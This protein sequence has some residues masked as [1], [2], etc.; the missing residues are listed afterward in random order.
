M[1]QRRPRRA[2]RWSPSRLTILLMV[3]AQVLVL[4][5][6]AVVGAGRYLAAPLDDDGLYA[7]L[8]MGSDQGPPRSGSALGGRMDAIQLVVVTA[9]RQ[10]VSIMSLPRDLFVPVPGMGTTKINAA[11]TAGPETAVAAVESVVGIEINDWVVTSFHGMIAGIDELGGVEVDVEQR[12]RD[13]IGASTDLQP[14]PQVLAGWQALG[15]TRDRKSRSNG[16]FGRSEGQ[17]KVLQAI[18]AKLFAENPD[19]VRLTQIVSMARRHT[20]MSIPRQRLF[21]LAALAMTIPPENVQRVVLD[22]A[23]GSAGEASVVRMTNAGRGQIADL[24]DDGYL[25]PPPG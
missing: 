5:A 19:P 16:D 7:M 6:G 13:P 17:T 20:Q 23:I 9:D 14:G 2:L 4:G 1:T 21:R 15:Y 24:V 12:L 22:G 18:H 10:H 11:L 25:G 8:V 3:V